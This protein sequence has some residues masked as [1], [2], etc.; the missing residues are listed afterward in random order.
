MPTLDEMF[1]VK[2]ECDE[3]V[4]NFRPIFGKD[5]HVRVAECIGKLRALEE[6]LVTKGKKP[7]GTTRLEQDIYDLQRQILF[8]IKS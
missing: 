8:L 1:Q 6:K 7:T 3:A 5:S 2:V 4:R